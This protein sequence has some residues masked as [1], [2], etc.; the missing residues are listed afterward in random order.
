MTTWTRHWQEWVLPPPIRIGYL[1]R[2]SSAGEFQIWRDGAWKTIEARR[3]YDETMADDIT[4]A[5][6]V[7]L[8]LALA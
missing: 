2:Q 1:Y 5:E 4:E 8:T 7:A 3:M 6:A